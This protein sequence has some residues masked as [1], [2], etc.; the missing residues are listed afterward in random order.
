M[1]MKASREGKMRRGLAIALAGALAG[2]TLGAGAAAAE[3][4]LEA[5]EAALSHHPQIWRDQALSVASEH[6]VEEAYADFLP[7]LDL[8]LSSG[9]EATSSPTTRGSGR[10]TVDMI[11]SE[12][13]LRLTQLLF[14]FYGT[15][16]RVESA[17]SE[18]EASN[19][20]LQA[21]S[22]RIA[23]LATRYFLDVLSAR[24]G[25]ALAEQNLGD[26]TT[27]RDLIS[28]RTEA[29]RAAEVDLDQASSRVALAKADLASR[30]GA[31][32][33]ATARFIENVGYLP[34]ALER[35]AVPDYPQAR[36][37]DA[38]LA[39]AMVRNPVG[40][41][42]T[43]QWDARR[44]DIEVERSAYFPRVDLEASSSVGD[45]IDGIRGG[46]MDAQLLV[47]MTWTLFD[48]L[49]NVA[50]NR[51]ASHEAN[52]AWQNDAEA[53]RAI[54]EL[55]RVAFRALETAEARLPQL[56]ADAD[57]STRTFEAYRQ[58]YDVGQRSL[59]DLLD[60]RDEMFTAQEAEVRG[61]Y[62]V[63][64][65]H[66]E[67]LFSMGLLLEHLGVVVFQDQEQYRDHQQQSG[68]MAAAADSAGLRQDAA[69]SFEQADWSG[70]VA[71]PGG[72][73]F[74]SW[75]SDSGVNQKLPESADSM[76]PV[77]EVARQAAAKTF[78]RDIEG[79]DVELV[80]AMSALQ[81]QEVSVLP[82][83]GL[84]DVLEASGAGAGLAEDVPLDDASSE[85][86]DSILESEAESVSAPGQLGDQA[87][88]PLPQEAG[89]EDASTEDTEDEEA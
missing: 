5:V 52:A 30:R 58:Q 51:R 73:E 34:G 56:R 72:K 74:G 32:R 4:M 83:S 24:E 10:G 18:L 81:E 36:D 45:N 50:R 82:A 35:P 25:V 15:S 19:A 84:S 21:T 33:E 38:A 8:D 6:A 14:D 40:H 49:G 86:A 48:G 41:S 39:V 65:A 70:E 66:Y 46:Q 79:I 61:S 85:P 2:G 54:R 43:A 77:P 62:A 11:R 47:R 26:L 12:A 88:P 13:S 20:D 60:A 28:G 17:E 16:N 80:P 76:E 23:R 1:A 63:L 53:R 29:G 9:Y 44:A 89:A 75:L 59:L 22:E 27:V 42:T 55:V 64:Q 69:M 57:A 87:A 68:K 78:R 71:V 67:L 31:E 3:T 7:D 37:L